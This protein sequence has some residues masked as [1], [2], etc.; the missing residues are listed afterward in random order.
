MMSKIIGFFKLNRWALFSGL[1][2]GTSYAPFPCW[3]VAFCYVPLWLWVTEETLSLRQIF[4]G[5]W[6]TQ[7]TLSLIGFHWVAFVTYEFGHIPAPLAVIVLIMFC[8]LV[9][10]YIPIAI[11]LAVALGRH[12]RFQRGWILLIIP[13]FLNMMERFWPSIFPWHLG[14]PLYSSGVSLYQWA[15][16][17]GF[18]GLSLLMLLSNSVIA[19]WWLNRK[20]VWILASLCFALGFLTWAGNFHAKDWDVT[21][22]HVQTLVV[23]GNIGNLEKEQVEKGQN[24]QE[25]IIDRF[26][27]LTRKGAAENPEAKL[28]IWPETAFPATF[29]QRSVGFYFQQKVVQTLRDLKM[30]MVTGAYS[31]EFNLQARRSTAYNAMAFLNQNGD[32]AGPLYRKTYLL[33]YG[34]YLPLSETFPFLLEWVPTVANFGRGQGPQVFS[35]SVE[36]QVLRLGPQICYEGLYPDFSRKLALEGAQ[37]FVNITND[38]W[39]GRPS[40]PLQH[41]YM[42]FARAVE[43][44]RPLIR[45]TNTG[46]SSVALASG[47]ILALSPIHQEWT[48]KFDVS[49]QHNPPLTFFS[50][51]GHF[52]ALLVL[53]IT[54]ITLAI[55]Y[56][57]G[58]IRR[59]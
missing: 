12:W 50:K 47:Q 54:M 37:I 49:Y 15:D 3:A 52:D 51:W 38:S 8:S 59:P 2:I 48:G 6:I 7:F 32:L 24:Y 46:V 57:Y 55:G 31:S 23:Q 16:V 41:M 19:V 25:S 17:I 11:T 9:H 22:A 58:R 1:L 43:N 39:F 18:L 14:Y 45:S 27:N 26:I 42:T 40:E 33:A 10:L 35:L 13:F 44:R 29:D 53:I 36:D 56:R 28:I 20:K 34:E 30:A 21:D 5:A 4:W